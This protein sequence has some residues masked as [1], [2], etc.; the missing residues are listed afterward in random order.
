MHKHCS[1]R[2]ASHHCS[3]CRPCVG[4]IGCA[5]VYGCAIWWKV[6]T[7]IKALLVRPRLPID[8]ELNRANQDCTSLAC[9]Q[10]RVLPPCPWSA[11]SMRTG[12]RVEGETMLETD[13]VD[14]VVLT[15]YQIWG[16][17][18]WP[19]RS[20]RRR[21]ISKSHVF[22]KRDT[23][24]VHR[25]GWQ[26]GPSKHQ[27]SSHPSS[28]STG[29]TSAV[30][31]FSLKGAVRQM[32]C[33]CCV[34]GWE[35]PH[36]APASVAENPINRRRWR[37]AVAQDVRDGTRVGV[38]SASRTQHP[39]NATDSRPSGT[40][41]FKCDNPSPRHSRRVFFTSDFQRHAESLYLRA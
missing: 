28:C 4:C 40:S 1:D 8:D 31:R 15:F 39:K 20:C 6:D 9:S 22:G 12:K 25:F 26:R 13:A 14:G 30:V 7:F 24:H 10:N 11:Q 36:S 34:G 5:Y 19:S 21:D 38:V 16:C 32:P 29:S 41:T 17:A 35:L 37:Y 23:R 2:T 33:H 3:S 27:N 18:R